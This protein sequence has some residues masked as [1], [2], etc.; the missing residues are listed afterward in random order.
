[1]EQALEQRVRVADVLLIGGGG[2]LVGGVLLRLLGRRFARRG[3]VEAG[4]GGAMSRV[5]WSEED[6]EAED[7]VAEGR[8]HRPEA[9]E[10]E[11][12]MDDE[13]PLRMDVLEK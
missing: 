8:W 12:I 1:M 11:D 10:E 5:S 3:R 2:T 4:A 13:S 6:A 9:H 7:M